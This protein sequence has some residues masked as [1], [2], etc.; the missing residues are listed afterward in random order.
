ML[1]PRNVPLQPLVDQHAPVG[2]PGRDDVGGDLVDRQLLVGHPAV[3]GDHHPVQAVLGGVLHDPRHR[4]HTVRAVLGVD[5]V[6]AP[7]RDE[8]VVVGVD[9]VR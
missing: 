3:V 6:I 4:V 2:C 7:Q 5:V 8:V 1:C 9:R